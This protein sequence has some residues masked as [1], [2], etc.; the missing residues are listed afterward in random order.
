MR[1]QEES[2]A[3]AARALAE[4]EAAE[5]AAAEAAAK[6][7]EEEAAVAAAAAAAAEG[8]AKVCTDPLECALHVP[9]FTNCRTKKSTDGPKTSRDQAV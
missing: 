5:A 6:K 1:C 8:E 4:K 2:E 7:A 3:A 9:L